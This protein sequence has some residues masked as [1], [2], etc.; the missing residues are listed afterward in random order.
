MLIPALRE[1]ASEP[2]LEVWAQRA[3]DCWCLVIQDED[4]KSTTLMWLLRVQGIPSP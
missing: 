4:W 2:F 1:V 3:G